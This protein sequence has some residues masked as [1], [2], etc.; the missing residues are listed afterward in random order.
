[1]SEREQGPAPSPAGAPLA[2]RAILLRLRF[3]VL[4]A[5]IALGASQWDAIAGYL[6]R[7]GSGKAAA[8]ATTSG[9]AAYFCPMHPSVQRAEPA[10]CPLCGMPLSR[11]EAGGSDSTRLAG[12][13]QLTPW[14]LAL[15]GIK[16]SIVS[17]QPLVYEATAAG[18]VTFDTTKTTKV[19]ATFPGRVSVLAVERTGVPVRQGD[20]ILQVQ[21][22]ELL[23][24]CSSLVSTAKTRAEAEQAADQAA[25]ER[26]RRD[27]ERTRARALQAGLT[28]AEIEQVIRTGE[29]VSVR[30]VASSTDGVLVKRY[31]NLGD[32]VHRGTEVADVVG[33]ETFTASAFLHED[34]LALVWEGTEVVGRLDSV[35]G[36]EFRGSIVEIA[37]IVSHPSHAVE[38]RMTLENPRHLP[39]REGMHVSVTFRVPVAD[40]ASF[41]TPA[42]A[43]RD[44]PVA[45]SSAPTTVYTCPEHGDEVATDAGTCHRCGA[46][47]QGSSL[48]ADERLMYWCPGHPETLGPNPGICRKCGTMELLPKLEKWAPEGTVLAVPASA[49]IDTGR[50]MVVYLE[51]EPGLFEPRAVV[52]APRAGDS[53]PVIA[54]L[55]AGDTVV[56]SGAF[57]L[58]AETRLNPS[59]SA[60]YFGGSGTSEKSAKPE[61]K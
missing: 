50:R 23:S 16:T 47:L 52:L 58:D 35:P 26:A 41:K 12:R 10:S 5:L 46:T 61:G 22:S 7:V 3:P 29:P 49:V 9:P 17:P 43:D 15:A 45:T 31:V 19:L 59:V 44:R 56:S 18:T 48:R 39:L 24:L 38:V 32:T 11:A 6:A 34:D 36:E 28:E 51:V 53:Y 8:P 25:V 1:V 20:P 2:V 30:P 21:S 27:E 54:G 37:S 14:R 33:L 4:F 40:T 13:I 60:T 57:L 42:G 55:V